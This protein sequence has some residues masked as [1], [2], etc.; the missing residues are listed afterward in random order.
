MNDEGIGRARTAFAVLRACSRW[1][2]GTASIDDL[3]AACARVGDWD[4]VL[5]QAIRHR[6]VPLVA[7]ACRRAPAATVPA[8]VVA[9]LDHVARGVAARNLALATSGGRLMQ[10]LGAAG[11]ASLCFKGPTLALLAYGSLALRSFDDLDVLV[12][13]DD[14]E[15]AWAVLESEGFRAHTSASLSQRRALVSLQRPTTYVR[16]RD[17]I[18]IDLHIAIAPGYQ[19]L[20]VAV[21]PTIA[22]AEPVNVAGQAMRTLPRELLLVLLASHGA[23][24]MWERLSWLT[25]IAALLQRQQDLDWERVIE[26]ATA[27]R[28]MRTLQLACRLSSLVLGNPVPASIGARAD[29]GVGALV[30]AAVRRM[31]AADDRPPSALRLAHFHLASM[32][33]WRDRVHYVT[34]MARPAEADAADSDA[35]LLTRLSRYPRRAVR[36]L[37]RGP[38]IVERVASSSDR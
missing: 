9:H 25:D 24:H 3:Q 11:I 31:S 32:D 1:H 14:V 2:V 13:P 38:G 5:R 12:S 4:A 28:S 27:S 29:D 7:S 33:R 23:K 10:V 16:A 17:G 36:L 21:E 18:T 15:R 37:V 35:S 22:G 34:A 8:S 20:R 30:D 19:S 6:V 26:I